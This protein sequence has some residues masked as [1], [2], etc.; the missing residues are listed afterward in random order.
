MSI[1]RITKERILETLEGRVLSKSQIADELNVDRLELTSTIDELRDILKAID[2]AIDHNA[3]ND[4][5]VVGEHTFKY[6][7]LSNQE[8]LEQNGVL[9]KPKYVYPRRNLADVFADLK[10]AE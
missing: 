3:T 8:N 10:S 5:E 6:Y 7:K 1:E 9:S 2:V 4:N